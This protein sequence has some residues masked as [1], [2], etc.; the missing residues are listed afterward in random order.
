[1]NLD[2][3]IIFLPRK[4]FHHWGNNVNFVTLPDLLSRQVYK[5]RLKA[6]GSYS[7][8]RIVP[9]ETT[10]LKS[11]GHFESCLIKSVVKGAPRHDLE[12]ELCLWWTRHRCSSRNLLRLTADELCKNGRFN[13]NV[14]NSIRSHHNSE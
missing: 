10:N 6:I 3:K 1:M 2:S 9:R 8:S 7:A 5:N 4:T 12:L 14:L 13:H 11:S